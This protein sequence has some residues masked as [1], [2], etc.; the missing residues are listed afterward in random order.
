[1]DIT[2]LGHS[3]FRLKGKR[4][5]VVT[6]P[7]NP[8]KVGLKFPKNIAA[9]IVTISHNHDDHNFSVVIDNIENAEKVVFNGVGEYEARGVEVIGIPTFHDNKD[10]SERGN[11][12]IYTIEIDGIYVVHC[13]DLGHVLK[14]AQVDLIENCDILL[15]PVGGV[16]TIDAE[17][18]AKIVTQLEPSVVIP[19]HYQSQGL[20]PKLFAE[21]APVSE[22]LREM[23]AETVVPITKYSVTREKLP[24][25]MQVMVFE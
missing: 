6:D 20:D 21:L 12:T 7:F 15:I 4:A 17:K 24:Q 14:D 25:E 10:G 9:D 19:M 11:N 8:E 22:F 16:Y 2:Y 5:T 23:G 13:G 1:M 3:S 18:A